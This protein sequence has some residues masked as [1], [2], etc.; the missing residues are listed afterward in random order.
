MSNLKFLKRL[1]VP[2][3][4]I[5]LLFVVVI[6][7]SAQDSD[8]QV[9]DDEVNTIAK[10]LY[11][12]ICES[13]PLDVCATQACADWRQVIRDKLGEGQSEEEIKAYFFELYGPRALAEPPQSGVTLMVWILPILVVLAGIVILYRYMSTSKKVVAVSKEIASEETIPDVPAK[14]ADENEYRARIER[15]LREIKK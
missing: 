14:P 12:P 10:D 3:L 8:G 6:P 7:A 15:E 5:V 2:T 13:T 9:T 4:F 11:C 1:I